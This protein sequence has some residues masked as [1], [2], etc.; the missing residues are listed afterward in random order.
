MNK[1]YLPTVVFML[2]MGAAFS[3][4][5]INDGSVSNTTINADVT[6]LAY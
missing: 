3:Q 4:Q 1:L 2:Y 5:K 6:V